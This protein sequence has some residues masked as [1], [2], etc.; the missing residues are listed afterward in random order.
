VVFD[1][2]INFKIFL[3][4]RHSFECRASFFTGV[5]VPI[6]PLVNWNFKWKQGT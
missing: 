6:I 2:F 1:Y 4:A 5:A 3:E